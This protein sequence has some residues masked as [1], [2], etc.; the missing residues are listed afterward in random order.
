MNAENGGMLC[1]P[2]LYSK[3]WTARVNGDPVPVENINGGFTGVYLAPGT[4]NVEL[5]Y[6]LPHF[7][8]AVTVSLAACGLWLLLFLYSVIRRK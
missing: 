2:I 5:V 1:V 6:S 4:S 3:N 7:G 8:L